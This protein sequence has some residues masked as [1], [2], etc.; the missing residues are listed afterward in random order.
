[1]TVRTWARD[2]ALGIRF[3]ATGGREGWTRTLLTAFGVGL[4]VAML[5]LAS[6]VPGMIEQRDARADA[7]T[8]VELKQLGAPEVAPSARTVLWSSVETSYRDR[9]VKGVLLR[10][11][12]ADPVRPPGVTA[13][14][15]PGEMVVS[16]ALGE[17]LRSP[18]GK[19][20]GERYGARVA[21]TIGDQG[22]LGSRELYFY[23]GNADITASDGGTRISGYDDRNRLPNPINPILVVLIVLVCVVLLAPVAVFVATA[24]RF[25]GERRDRRLAALRLVGA[26]ARMVHRIAGGEAL[27]GALLGLAVGIGLFFAARPLAG[28]I[29]LDELS[30]F[31]ADVMPAPLLGGLIVV[32]V[33]VSAV[34]VTLFALRTV[35]IEPL[36]VVRQSAAAPRRLWWRL[37]LPVAG[38]ALLFTGRLGRDGGDAEVFPVA[39]GAV[40]V[41]I[42]LT[43]LLPWLVDA[44]VGRLNGGPVPWQLA[45]RRLQ[46]SSGPAARAVSGIM[47]AVAGAI[48]LQMLFSAVEGDFVKENE[49]QP[50]RT[51]LSVDADFKGAE[52]ARRMVTEFERTEGVRKVTDTTQALLYTPPQT[53]EEAASGHGEVVTLTV[54]DCPTLRELARITA[55]EDGDAFVVLGK[56]KARAELIARSAALGKPYMTAAPGAPGS[57]EA[58]AAAADGGR[59]GNWS[60]PKGSPTVA[61]VADVMGD[62][63]PGI[64]ATPGA[65]D[66][67]SFPT[68]S[69][70]ALVSVD[71]KASEARE[72]IRNIV[73]RT[74]PA[75]NVFQLQAVQEDEQFANVRS[76]LLIGS[77]ATMALIAASMLV[78]Q[79]EQLRERRKLLSVLVAFGTR[80]ST[81]AWSVLW[82]TAVPVVLGTALA[83]VGGLG[84]G[85][86]ML[87][88][89]R[90]RSVDW[91]G[92]LPIAGAGAAVIVVVTALSLP[93]LYRMMRPDG[94]RTE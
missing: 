83:I 40:L 66:L 50:G 60:L 69:T 31:P 38:L 24:V 5:L 42:G 47:V 27:F 41:L 90:S 87:A 43:A 23:L 21:G 62:A 8:P 70:R 49:Q 29:G 17:L 52:P 33:P 20:L 67:R 54:G 30:A 92:F 7:R 82:Q 68:A 91:W 64:F 73:A 80:R 48:A 18:E 86:V 76:G 26:D 61:T 78:S 22:L 81:V 45:V 37:L 74:D 10:A 59:P 65:V 88:L 13:F 89:V 35:A 79:I 12:G 39:A 94:L 93:P 85:L 16:P 9:T 55:C 11:D 75:A 15:K 28:G 3:G 4:G 32:A 34:V 44:V 57:P 77:M 72:H 19:L 36:G 46:L 71:E 56:D 2:L 84:L 58:A 1:M 25:G 63:H 6:S 14:P 51:Q 53:P